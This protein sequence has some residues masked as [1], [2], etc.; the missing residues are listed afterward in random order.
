MS[1]PLSVL[2]RRAFYAAAWDRLKGPLLAS[3][4]PDRMAVCVSVE[5]LLRGWVSHVASLFEL[6]LPSKDEVD[7][8]KSEKVG[9]KSGWKGRVNGLPTRASMHSGP[10]PAGR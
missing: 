8:L 3:A 6:A 5:V 7:A 1:L 10:Q 4:A 2:P 9:G